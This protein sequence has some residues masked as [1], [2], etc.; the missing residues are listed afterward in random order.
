MSVRYKILERAN[1]YVNGEIIAN[2]LSI[3]TAA[4]EE[5]YTLEALDAKYSY[6]N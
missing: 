6:Y 4:N 1:P 3:D 2:Y 5:P